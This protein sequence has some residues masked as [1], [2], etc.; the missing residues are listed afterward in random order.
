MKKFMKMK[1]LMLIAVCLL[2]AGILYAQKPVR[3]TCQT[4]KGIA[5]PLCLWKV[6]AGE[7]RLVAEASFGNGYCEFG[8]VPEA[9]GFYMVGNHRIDCQYPL[10]LKAG[11][12]VSL[13]MDGD[14]VCLAGRHNSPENEVLYEWVR[15]S[16]NLRELAMLLNPLV[17]YEQF[18]PALDTVLARAEAFKVDVRTKNERFNELM[19]QMVDADLNLY[20]LRFLY[21]PRSKQ[22]NREQRPAFYAGIISP[23]RFCDTT[24]LCMP[25]GMELLRVYMMYYC[26]ENKKNAADLREALAAI[27]CKEVRGAIVVKK[28]REFNRSYAEF[29]DFME[30]AAPHINESQAA[31]LEARASQLYEAREGVPAVDFAYPDVEGVERALSDYRGKVVVVDVWATWCGPCKAQMPALK[32][33]EKEFEGKEVVFVGVS[34]DKE[35]DWGKWVQFVKDEQLPGVQL[36]ANGWSK[37]T[38]DYKITGIP[39]FMLFDKAGNVIAADAPHPTS[40]ALKRMIE[41]ALKE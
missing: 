34:V 38:E 2:F 18:F 15:L 5:P 1:R 30:I 29:V 13:Y 16:R 10:Y 3:V 25:Y 20:A 17:T 14:T 6:Q 21:S 4:G 36:F 24:V 39:H 7:M 41:N 12:R 37:I 27:P 23:D 31:Y 28:A 19:R 9:D 8:F 35:D 26:L 40:P 32:L 33:L 11:E 22:P